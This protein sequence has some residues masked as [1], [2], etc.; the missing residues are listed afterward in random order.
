MLRAGIV[1]FCVC[2]SRRVESLPVRLMEAG[3]GT[4]RALLTAPTG[5]CSAL[6]P[7]GRGPGPLSLSSKQAVRYS[8]A[9][10]GPNSGAL[11]I[12]QSACS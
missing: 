8:L 1:S 4:A 2:F 6:G 7:V 5:N 9:S 11:A 12:F 10:T 3:Q